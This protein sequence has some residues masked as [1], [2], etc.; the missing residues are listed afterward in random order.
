MLSTSFWSKVHVDLFANMEK[1]RYQS[2]GLD[3]MRGFVDCTM[4][5]KQHSSADRRTSGHRAAIDYCGAMVL[6][7]SDVSSPA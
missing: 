3:K 2:G 4:D 5:E 7:S 1:S 6:V